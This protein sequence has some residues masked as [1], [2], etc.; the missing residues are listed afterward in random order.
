MNKTI[1][2]PKRIKASIVAYTVEADWVVATDH[3]HNP[4]NKKDA[5]KK[6]SANHSESVDCLGEIV[7]LTICF[8]L[9]II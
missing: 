3:T 5:P 9:P 4:D 1:P 6:M 8:T 7:L 2:S